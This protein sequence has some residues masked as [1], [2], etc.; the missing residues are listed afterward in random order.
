MIFEWGISKNSTIYVNG[1]EFRVTGT[2]K[3]T[4]VIDKELGLKFNR[5]LKFDTILKAKNG[6]YIDIG[7]NNE[8]ILIEQRKKIKIVE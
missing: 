3:T 8:D 4:E 1:K 5:T 6:R 7:A 2:F